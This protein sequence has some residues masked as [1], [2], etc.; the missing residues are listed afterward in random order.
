MSFPSL[1]DNKDPIAPKIFTFLLLSIS[2][3]VDS[4]DDS[5]Y[6][7]QYSD[8]DSQEPKD[9]SQVGDTESNTDPPETSDSE[10]K[11]DFPEIPD[12]EE[13]EPP[14]VS[15]DSGV[16]DQCPDDPKKTEPGLCGC[17]LSETD[18]T[19]TSI[20]GVEDVMVGTLFSNNYAYFLDGSDGTVLESI[21]YGTPVDAI[22]AIP[23]IVGD[24]SWEMVVGGRNGLVTCYSGGIDTDCNDNGIPDWQD[25]ADCE[26]DPAC[27]DCDGNGRPDECDEAFLD[28]D[29]FI[30]Q[31]LLDPPAQDPILVCMFDQNADDS[32]GT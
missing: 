18:C 24:G 31:L 21:N 23:D 7:E 26:G 32:C 8:S 15:S 2:G 4:Y 1:I 29:L 22:A 20:L 6:I 25:I 3:C 13:N 17:N 5:Y 11:A 30:T 27:N 12:T 10:T 14:E 9:T 19:I 16:S 28:M